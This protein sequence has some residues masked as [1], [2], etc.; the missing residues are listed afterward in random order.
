M[1]ID[2]WYTR[3]L[4]VRQKTPASV[5][6]F[7]THLPVSDRV[8]SMTAHHTVGYT[9]GGAHWSKPR[10]QT[11]LI[12][13]VCQ[14]SLI[15]YKGK[16]DRTVA[17]YYAHP[18]S[19][20]ARVNGTILASDDNGVTF[21]RSLQLWPGGFGYTGLACGLPGG[22]FDCAV[23][24]DSQSHGLDFLTFDSSDVR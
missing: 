22:D 23:L 2:I 1:E 20:V 11:D 15:S 9:D 14:A 4:L 12:T 24:Y 8:F 17:L 3:C 5:V 7:H 13:P 10:N 21:S 19:T 6:A 16:R 18:Y